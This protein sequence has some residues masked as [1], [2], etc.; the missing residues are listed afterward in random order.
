MVR[1]KE[2]F[3]S[4]GRENET[5]LP[6]ITRD[7]VRERLLGDVFLPAVVSVRFIG[8][9]PDEVV[10]KVFDA[11]LFH[12]WTQKQQQQ[13]QQQQ[14]QRATTSSSSPLASGCCSEMLVGV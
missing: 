7:V 13:Q 12:L 8:V 2:R 3:E 11:L 10:K 14:Q 6:S 5:S 9:L 1:V 4:F